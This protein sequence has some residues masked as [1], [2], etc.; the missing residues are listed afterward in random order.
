MAKGIQYDLATGVITG[1]CT[2]SIDTDKQPMPDGR[3]QLVVDEGVQYDGQKV[4]LQ[5]LTLVPDTG[6]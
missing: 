2:P 1:C 6:T 5:T 4:D 3:G